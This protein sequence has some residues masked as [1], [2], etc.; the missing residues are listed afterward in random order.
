V[1]KIR[2]KGEVLREYVNR[3]PKLDEHFKKELVQEYD[4]YRE[5]LIDTKTKEEALEVFEDEIKKNEEKYKSDTLIEC[6]EGSPHNQYMEILANYGLIV[7]FRDN[8]IED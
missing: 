6:L 7:F 2:D 8:M 1:Y 4:R 3:Y 5:L